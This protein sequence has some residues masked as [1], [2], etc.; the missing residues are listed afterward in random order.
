[1]NIAGA[2]KQE[3][4]AIKN[5]PLLLTSG[6]FWHNLNHNGCQIRWNKSLKTFKLFQ[7][8]GEN[9]PSRLN[10][11]SSKHDSGIKIQRPLK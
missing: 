4:F 10:Q 7:V 3:G 6:Y 1:M 11:A 2:E 5:S 9:V 8:L